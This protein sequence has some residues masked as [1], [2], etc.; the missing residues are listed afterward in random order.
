[1][2]ASPIVDGDGEELGRGLS[3]TRSSQY[4]AGDSQPELKSLKDSQADLHEEAKLEESP[5][6]SDKDSSAVISSTSP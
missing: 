2:P 6:K 3:R 5:K 1:M 4:L